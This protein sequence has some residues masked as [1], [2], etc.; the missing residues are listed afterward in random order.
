VTNLLLQTVP[1]KLVKP[2]A[3][4]E[5]TVPSARVLGTGA[6]TVLTGPYAAA[7]RWSKAGIAKLTNYGDASGV[8]IRL[9]PGTSWVALLP[10]GSTVH[11]T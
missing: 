6:A 11:A 7:G 4:S 3:R 5:T 8:S 9:T 2:I 1:Y 10:A